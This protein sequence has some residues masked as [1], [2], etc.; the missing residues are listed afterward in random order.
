VSWV[1][2]EA[3]VPAPVPTEAQNANVI[4]GVA[5]AACSIGAAVIVVFDFASIKASVSFLMQNIRTISGP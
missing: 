1:V 2:D 3:K 5:V 4:A